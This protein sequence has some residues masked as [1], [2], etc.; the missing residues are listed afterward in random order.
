MEAHLDGDKISGAVAT[1][2]H[3]A[4]LYQEDLEDAFECAG[5]IYVPHYPYWYGGI[6]PESGAVYTGNRFGLCSNYTDQA[7][8][9]EENRSPPHQALH[10][11]VLSVS[12]TSGILT[13]TWSIESM[14]FAYPGSDRFK[15]VDLNLG[16]NKRDENPNGDYYWEAVR[17]AIIK[18]ALEAS[19]HYHQNISKILLH[20]DRSTNARFQEVLREV[21]DRALENTPE[22]FEQEPVFAAAR[23]AAEMAKRVQWKYNQTNSSTGTA[24]HDL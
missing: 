8:C 20:G 21:V 3:L 13:S 10:E 4:A 15:F 7:L 16:W 18:P 22:I 11:N 24:G 2:P 1:I 6:F 17:D 12:Y 23:G 5:L 9:E 19:N 14:G